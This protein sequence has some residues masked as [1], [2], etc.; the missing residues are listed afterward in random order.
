MSKLMLLFYPYFNRCEDKAEL[1]SSF[2][3]VLDVLD[4]NYSSMSRKISMGIPLNE[5]P[6]LSVELKFS[7]LSSFYVPSKV[8]S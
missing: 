6:P 2:R 7:P 8:I 5:L 1:D 3:L 4:N